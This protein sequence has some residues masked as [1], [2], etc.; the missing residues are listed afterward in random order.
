MGDIIEEY[1]GDGSQFGVEISY[2]REDEKLGTVGALPSRTPATTIQS[3]LQEGNTRL[4]LSIKDLRQSGLSEVGL[5][6]LQALQREIADPINNPDAQE[7]L[8]FAP[9]ILGNPEGDEVIRGLSIPFESIESGIGVALTA[10]SGLNN[11]EL[12][13]QSNLALLQIMTQLGPGLVQL[14]QLAQQ[15]AG[16]PLGQVATQLFEGGRQLALRVMEDFDVRNPEEIVPNLQ[17]AL[18][19]QTAIA[20][21]Q[22]FS[23]LGASPAAAAGAI[24]G[25]QGFPGF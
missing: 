5:R 25:A 3:L 1:F 8:A 15:A 18:G 9:R 6:V 23:P 2:L 20:Q 22:P 11:K 17:A 7:Y 24:P 16:T 14:A 13:K 12:S 4:D 21:G 19:A 10:T